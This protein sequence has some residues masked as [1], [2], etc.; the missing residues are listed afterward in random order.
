[1]PVDVL[2]EGFLFYKSAPQ[3]KQTVLKI[4]DLT[5]DDL[6][7]AISSL[8]TRL[9]NGATRLVETDDEIQL[10][11]CP[12]MS[13]VVEAMR[14]SELKN[15]IGKAGAETL[16]IILYRGPVSRFDIDQIRGV[17]SSYVLRNLMIRGL[18]DRTLDRKSNNYKFNATPNLLAHLGV[19]S[20]TELSDFAKINDALD[21]FATQSDNK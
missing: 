5:E 21:S 14:K 13:P 15:D 8:K 4:F 7:N 1:M 2:I 20:K 11:L 16:A 12:E 9:A 17:N 19:T 18:V 6:S 3:K 10:V